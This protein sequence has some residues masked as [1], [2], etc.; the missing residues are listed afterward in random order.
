[1]DAVSLIKNIAEDKG[2]VHIRAESYPD[3]Y[4]D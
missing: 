2:E 4:V 1:M 3:V